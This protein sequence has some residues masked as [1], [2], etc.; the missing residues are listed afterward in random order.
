MPTYPYHC[1]EC[2]HAFELFQK[3]TDEPARDC[4][5]CQAKDKV[6]RDIGGGSALL[7]FKGSGYYLTDY[8][9]ADSETG[10]KPKQGCSCPCG[11]PKDCST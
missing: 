7:Q 10:A 2:G 4:P 11:K 9:R 5:A 8:K 3:I 1:Q 6:Q